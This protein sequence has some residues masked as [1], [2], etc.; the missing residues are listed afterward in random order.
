MSYSSNEG[1]IKRVAVRKADNVAE[2]LLF[3]DISDPDFPLGAWAIFEGTPEGAENCSP[4]AVEWEGATVSFSVEDIWD[5]I[6]NPDHDEQDF[7][8][9]PDEVMIAKTCRITQCP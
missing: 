1:I 9:G 6:E 4:F 8:S 2:C 5:T 7:D 3:V